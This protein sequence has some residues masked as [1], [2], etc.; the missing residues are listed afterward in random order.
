MYLR[1]N[2]PIIRVIIYEIKEIVF[3]INNIVNGKELA[4]I[5][6]SLFKKKKIINLSILV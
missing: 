1:A 3:I 4:T 2:Y 6:K 5:V